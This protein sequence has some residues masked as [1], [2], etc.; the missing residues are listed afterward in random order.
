MTSIRYASIK[1]APTLAQLLGQLGYPTR[2]DDV[3]A[4]L[5]VPRQYPNA[6]ALVADQNGN[7]V[8]LVTCHMFPAIHVTAPVA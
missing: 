1:D 2:T 3:A 7:V 4:R 8:G 5:L 6:V